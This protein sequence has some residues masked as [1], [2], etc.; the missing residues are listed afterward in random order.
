MYDRFK[1]LL[2]NLNEYISY[3]YRDG[4]DPSYEIPIMY[5]NK[6]YSLNDFYP[7]ELLDYNISSDEG[8]YKTLLY[9]FDKKL[10]DSYQIILVD[11]GIF[12]RYYK[13]IY[14]PEIRIPASETTSFILGFWHTYKELCQLI[15]QRSL[16]YLFG[17]LFGQLFINSPLL[18]KPKLGILETYFNWMMLIYQKN[19]HK[20]ESL[21]L[22]S[23][24]IKKKLLKNIH[25]IFKSAIPFVRHFYIIYFN[26]KFL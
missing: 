21:I 16:T 5:Q 26:L 22:N 23:K 4:I 24:G 9:L 18:L 1:K 17:P 7:I 8:L 11:I 14:N 3:S 13:W 19:D 12:W 2:E 15:Y 6:T 25:W 20:L 10:N